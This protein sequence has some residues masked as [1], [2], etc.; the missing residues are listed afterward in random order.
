MLYRSSPIQIER[1]D[2]ARKVE[3]RSGT[4]PLFLALMACSTI[5]EFT[6]ALAESTAASARVAI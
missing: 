2:D 5:D 3:I 1:C 6:A 4:L